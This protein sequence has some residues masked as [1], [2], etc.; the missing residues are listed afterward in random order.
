[1]NTAD[2][3]PSLASPAP[4]GWYRVWLPRVAATTLT[5]LSVAYGAIWLFNGTAGFIITLV[6]S[7]FVAFALLPA[8]ETL[9]ARGVR[10]GV[11]T[12]LVMGGAGVTGGLFGATVI[13]VAFRQLLRLIQAA[14]DYVA[15]GVAWANTTFGLELS[16]E[17]IVSEFAIDTERLQELVVD[18]ASGVLGLASSAAGVVFRLLTI[19]LFVFYIL[20]DLPRLRTALLRRMRP[21]VQIHADTVIRITISK[22]GGY[23]YSRG[24]LALL[25][26]LVHYVTFR[27]IGVPF[28]LALALWVGVISQFI[29]AIGTY[30]AG[31]FPLLIALAEDPPDA[32]WVLVV[33]VAYQQL[34]NYVL[35]PRITAHTMDLHPAVAFGS[36]IV[37]AS[38]LG[39]AGALLALPAAATIVALI[40]TYADHY[41][42]VAT[43]PATDPDEYESRLLEA[44]ER[45]LRSH[46][47]T[48]RRKAGVD[49]AAS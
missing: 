10:R 9:S 16:T 35:A 42:V 21:D 32:I 38:L 18:N 46:W 48:R 23:V 47:R 4:P 49:R 11:A 30:L 19:G 39:V 14:P 29:P 7:V 20:A 12:G 28:A 1:M 22:V 25:A 33:I 44:T 43:E 6:L 5:V 2:L 24:L 41:E 45:R 15:A 40:Q 8:V 37:G 36:A 34:E 26:A 3:D 13:S 31:V 27:I 17:R